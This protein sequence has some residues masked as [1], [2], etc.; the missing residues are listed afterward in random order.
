M[1]DAFEKLTF[2][3]DF[4]DLAFVAKRVKSPKDIPLE[5]FRQY[6]ELGEEDQLVK[7]SRTLEWASN[8]KKC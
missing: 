8:S 2:K 6:L 5:F 4:L 3:K 7:L 1:T